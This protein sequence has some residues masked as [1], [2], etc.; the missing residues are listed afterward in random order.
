[1]TTFS[2]NFNKLVKVT[3]TEQQHVKAEIQTT[4]TNNKNIKDMDESA[5]SHDFFQDNDAIGKKKHSTTC[6]KSRNFLSNIAYVG[7][8]KEDYYNRNFIF[9]FYLLLKKKSKSFFAQ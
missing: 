5:K 7:I 2:E 6:I 1:M 4:T 9:D 3:L 8:N